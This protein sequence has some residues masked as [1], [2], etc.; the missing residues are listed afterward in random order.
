M[1]FQYEIIPNRWVHPETNVLIMD[2][3]M[4]LELLPEDC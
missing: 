3:D 2:E 1:D 4:P